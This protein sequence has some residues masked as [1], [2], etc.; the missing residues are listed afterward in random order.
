MR[1]LLAPLVPVLVGNL[2]LQP[3]QT[4]LS[5][6]G[7][8]LGVAVVVAI[9]LA[10]DSTRDAHRR[11]E[12]ARANQATH[13]VSGGP[14]GVPESVLVRLRVAG[15]RSATPYLQGTVRIDSPAGPKVSVV[16]L[17]PL[18]GTGFLPTPAA[19][20]G[21]AMALLG[22]ER[23]AIAGANL[24]RAGPSDDDGDEDGEATAAVH[25]TDASVSSAGDEP[26]VEPRGKSSIRVWGSR[27]TVELQI[28]RVL[29]ALDGSAGVLVNTGLLMDMATAQELLGRVGWIDAVHLTAPKSDEAAWLERIRA[30]LPPG[31]N[32]ERVSSRLERATRLTRAFDTNLD[33]L[34]LLA[35]VVGLLLVF[36]AMT[37]AVVVRRAQMGILRALGVTRAQLIVMVL[38]EAACI[39][40]IASVVGVVFG[41]VLAGELLGLVSRTVSDL[42]FDVGD[43][44]LAIRWQTILVATMLGVVGTVLAALVPAL[45]ASQVSPTGAVRRST[46]EE[47]TL[48]YLPRLAL[49]GITSMGIGL[50]VLALSG[51][52][53][54][55]GFVSLFCL[56]IGAAGTTPSIMIHLVNLLAALADKADWMAGVIAVRGVAAGISR[57]AVAVAALTVALGATLGVSIMISS[58]RGTVDNW[59][60]TTLQADLYVYATTNTPGLGVPERLV[61][62]LKAHADVADIGL[63]RRAS[64]PAADGP[65]DVLARALGGTATDGFEL[66]ATDNVD[67]AAVWRRF[68]AG[69]VLVSEPYA[70]RRQVGPG[71][72][73]R[74][75][76]V[77]GWRELRIVGVYRDYGAEQG[78]VLMSLDTYRALFGD[79]SIGTVGIFLRD[80]DADAGGSVREL[81][82]EASRQGQ[83][84]RVTSAQQIHELSLR[85]FDRTF[86]VTEVLRL[87]T[88]V[89]A[90]I[91]VMSAL[92]ALQLE[93][94]R[95]LA[96]LRAT[97]FTR[98]QSG[99][100]VVL[101]TGTVGLISGVLALPMGVMTGAF[102]V[103]VINE[104]A[105]GWSVVLAVPPWALAQAVVLAI[106][107]ALLA[108]L[109]PAIRLAR[110]PVA[111]ALRYE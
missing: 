111:S 73:V 71:G 28:V 40:V 36:N 11:L 20:A 68:S 91:G 24:P 81:V 104:R 8:A 44:V 19:D 22:G 18:V 67:V 85:V 23:S 38:L 34:G 41:T 89:V 105:F 30:L 10:G 109:Y 17:S 14:L 59:L 75:N 51:A 66:L 96:V 100:S 29:P 16:A 101:Q 39:G 32:I 78:T 64:V 54:G 98:W 97:G 69:E 63:G 42:Y 6:L 9:D 2:R 83:R 74:L 35:L 46:L 99:L 45:E 5:I 37:F 92:M 33:M 62:Q 43:A 79:T 77:S 15:E 72:T 84:L 31:T 107:A 94:A 60:D 106:A 13:H 87:V 53:L 61:A 27:G 82:D 7:V 80:A 25:V 4:L 90:F 56:V 93:R 65:V 88:L 12:Q 48:G 95:E 86:A 110:Q 21:L 102:L 1:E 57:T 76:T 55:A 49:A 3:G 26:P 50:I 103:S 108:G 47:R 52:S 58:F 70:S